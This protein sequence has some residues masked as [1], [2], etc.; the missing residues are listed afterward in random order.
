MDRRI[1]LR[2]LTGLLAG[3]A[4]APAAAQTAALPTG[5][6]PAMVEEGRKLFLGQGLCL[7]CHGV[8]GRGGTGPDLTDTFWFHQEARTFDGLIKAITTGF[9]LEVSES[10]QIMPPRG[11]SSLSEAQ[12]RA[13]AAYVWT[14]SRGGIAR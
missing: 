11:G 9:S 12:V 4:A 6:T 1:R 8:D 3:I 14:L 7:A 10:G 5:V 2:L 13:V